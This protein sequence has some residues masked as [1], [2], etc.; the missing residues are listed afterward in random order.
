M[1]RDPEYS[2]QDTLK[3]FPKCCI[4]MCSK[5]WYVKLTPQIATWAKYLAWCLLVRSF[6]KVS[7]SIKKWNSHEI[8]CTS[9][10][11][12]L[13]EQTLSCERINVVKRAKDRCDIVQEEH[14]IKNKYVLNSTYRQ[15]RPVLQLSVCSCCFIFL[16]QAISCMFDFRIEFDTSL[17]PVSTTLKA[18][19][20]LVASNSFR[21]KF[22]APPV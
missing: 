8:A 18:S 7:N 2:N 6:S 10:M 9:K 3:T 19:Y 5:W 20:S 1:R 17:L 14:Q 15:W 13:H 4:H 21:S 22:W 16:V 12:H 11:K